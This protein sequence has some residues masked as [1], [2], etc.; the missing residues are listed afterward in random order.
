[1]KKV[2]FGI[3]GFGMIVSLAVVMSCGGGSSGGGAA[4]AGSAAVAT[5]VATMFASGGSPVS[6]DEVRVSESV[7]QPIDLTVTCPAG[8]TATLTGSIDINADES[9]VSYSGSIDEVL[10][11]CTVTDAEPPTSCGFGD[12]V[13]NGTMT[14]TVNGSGTE[15]SFTLS[16]T[17]V[18]TG[19]TFTYNGN[20]LTCDI[21]LALNIDSS[22]TWD[23]TNIMDAMS[24]SICGSDWTEIRTALADPD[25]MAALCAAYDAAA[26][27]L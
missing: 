24:G 17:V 21:D 16:E 9:S 20:T 14:V 10:A 26:T 4:N 15:T 7:N 5:S 18:G 25:A 11:D 27:E 23:E 2:L 3:L 12:V 22:T 1:M 6:L 13:G 8:G 19:L